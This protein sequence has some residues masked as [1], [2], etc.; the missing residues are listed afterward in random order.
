MKFKILLKTKE[1]SNLYI[2]IFFVLLFS[3]YIF[4]SELKKEVVDYEK[5]FDSIVK[6]KEE[7]FKFSSEIAEFKDSLQA[8]K[9]KW[10]D[11][12]NKINVY[13]KK[14]N[15]E[16]K[17]FEDNPIVVNYYSITRELG[18]K[19][20]QLEDGIDGRLIGKN[21]EF[22]EI[23]S[24]ID[25]LEKEDDILIKEKK[26]FYE[27]NIVSIEKKQ[28]NLKELKY[29]SFGGILNI[30][31][32]KSFELDKE[33]EQTKEYKALEAEIKPL[34]AKFKKEFTDKLNANFNEID[35]LYKKLDNIRKDFIKS[36]DF[37]LELKKIEEEIKKLEIK[38][39]ESSK[40]YFSLQDKIRSNK[41][42]EVNIF[43]LINDLFNLFKKIINQKG[44]K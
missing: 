11:L 24:K 41:D 44:K 29:E 10:D 35:S 6:K 42:K 40:E 37:P 31:A 8:D 26:L 14:K 28:K 25:K 5:M 9:K 18:S 13:M 20:K 17:K 12:V 39:K 34:Q 1:A 33:V 43:A 30:A 15:T 36:K 22:K 16:E 4:A 19:K 23:K 38:E 2:F 7:E 21:L 27:N 32:E 3:N